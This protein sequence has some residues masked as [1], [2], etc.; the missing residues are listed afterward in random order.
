M[1]ETAYANRENRITLIAAALLGVIAFFWLYSP[2]LLGAN[3]DYW[4]NPRH[5]MLAMIGGF[6]A[7]LRAPWTFPPTIVGSLTPEPVSIVYTDSIPWLALLLKITGLGHVVSPLGLFLFIGYPLQALGMVA[8]LR[9]LGVERRGVLLLGAVL[10]LMFPPW[11]GRQFGHIALTAHWILLFAAATAVSSIREGLTRQRIVRFAALAAIAVG[12]HAYHLVPVGAAFG[13]ALI[14]EVLQRR[15][16]ALRRSAGA[17]IAVLAATILPALLLGYT[18]G[19]GHNGGADALGLYAM[20]ALSPILPQGSQAAGQVWTGVWFTKVIDPTGGVQAFEGLQYLGAGGVILMLILLVTVIRA[21]SLPAMSVWLR[22]GPLIAACVA[23]TVWAIGWKVY[24]GSALVAEV[25]KPSGAMAELL[26]MFR[27]HGRFFWLVGYLILAAGILWASRL[28]PQVGLTLLGVLVVVQAWDLQPMRAGLRDTYK[29]QEAYY[30]A[31][32]RSAEALRGRQ[33]IFFPSYFCTGNRRDGRAI[34]ELAVLAIRKDGRVNT[35]P[36]ARSNDAACGTGIDGL[37]N[38]AAPNDPRIFVVMGNGKR[39]GGDLERVAWRTDCYRFERGVMCGRGLESL[40]L[41]RVHPQELIGGDQEAVLGIR[42]DQGVK[43]AELVQGWAQA[44]PGGKGIWSMEKQAVVQLTVP[45][46][47]AAAGG[48]EIELR[49]IGFSDPP[50]RPQRVNV[51]VNGH[52]VEPF[53][54]DTVDFAPYTFAVPDGAAPDG[55]L[56][57]VF[58]LPDARA[59]KMDPRTLGIALQTVTVFRSGGA[60]S[61]ARAANTQ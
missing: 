8:L 12:V 23:L 4:Q 39:G 57:L 54:V 7:F 52:K 3:G 24:V 60:Q 45:A 32:L 14:S 59:S 9:A 22:W 47:A 38:D 10:A 33:W 51:T 29:A 61:G 37:A 48:L 13:A 25:P 20:N 28:K 49:A 2:A 16:G 5:D 21:R 31:S 56:T 11:M 43:P 15:P 6:E 40:G 26:G 17:A 30:P 36:T 27:A 44:D 58:D 18:Q 53:K 55:K 19:R 1:S 41:T 42:M 34:A 35:Y 46:A 50:P